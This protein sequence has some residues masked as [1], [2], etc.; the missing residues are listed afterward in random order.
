MIASGGTSSTSQIICERFCSFGQ[1]GSAMA[2]A[3]A[4]DAT[5][6]ACS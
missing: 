6:S 3:V 4:A 5:S 2:M 1:K